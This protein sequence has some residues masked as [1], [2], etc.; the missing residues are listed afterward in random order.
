MPWEEDS[1]DLPV[2]DDLSEKTGIDDLDTPL[3]SFLILLPLW[4]AGKEKIHYL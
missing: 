1:W 4:P 2:V 3:K